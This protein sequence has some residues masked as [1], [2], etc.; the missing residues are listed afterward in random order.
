MAF[1]ENLG[2]SI[3]LYYE[4][5]VLVW[6]TEALRHRAQV[7]LYLALVGQG[8]KKALADISNLVDRN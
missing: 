3:V 2:K 5:Y 4:P 8:K 7:Y 1:A 6:S